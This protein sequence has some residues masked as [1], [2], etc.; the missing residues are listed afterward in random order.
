MRIMLALLLAVS[1][2]ACSLRRD[3]SGDIGNA[4]SELDRAVWTDGLRPIVPAAD[5]PKSL[6]PL[7]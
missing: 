7:K 3:F 2:S 4:V 5:K 1:V 6:P